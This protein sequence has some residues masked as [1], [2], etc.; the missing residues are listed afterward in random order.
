MNDILSLSATE[1]GRR[2]KAGDISPVDAVDACLARI[3]ATEP[4]LNAYVRVLADEARAA[5]KQAEK[6]IAA[7]QW[8]GPMH[9][10]PVAL[11]DLYDLAHVPTTASS[12]V[13]E[14]W[15]P[16]ADS[17]AA[18]RL[19]AAG[20]IVLGKTHTHEFAYGI[21]T[22]TTR[23]PW[24]TERTPGGSSGGSGA[25]VASS[26]AFMAM[27]S[28]T[29]GSIRIPAGLCGTVGLKP[30]FGRVSRAG[31]TSLSW[32]LDH[33]GPLT[34]TVEDAATCLQV[35][36]GHDPRDPGSGDEPVP[37][38]SA[39]LHDG[40]KG[41]R[42][43]VPTN[44]F[45]DQL[46]PEVEAAVRQAYEQL[47]ALGAELVDV[48]LPMPE[49]I[50]AVEFAILLPEASD[51][52]RQML[53]DSA[54]LYNDDVRVMLEAG[55]FVP[56]TTYIRAQRVR[57][58]L[59]QEFRKLYDKVDVIVAPT[60]AATAVTAGTESITWPDG[61]EE[62]LISA[63]TRFALPGNVTGLPALSVPC[64]FSSEGLPVG[65]QAIGRP[66]DEAT[67]LRLGAAYESATEWHQRRPDI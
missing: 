46:D 26:G 40:I 58:L 57:N 63:Y 31:I 21:V 35:L 49:Q 53:R 12:R 41:L 15:T 43:G 62:P 2:I 11:K 22:P 29:G 39:G 1:L 17:A 16:N 42:V 23:N 30:T 60:I 9:G 27:G 3:E 52:H 33:A 54:H 8:K 13:R 66:F 20:A 64:G 5:A 55:E 61:S 24:D 65:F 28:D 36:A 6:E 19:K 67:I 4:K 56:A 32:G 45:F 10:V 7:G 50:V 38:Y 34:R 48:A 59:Q 25:T 18:E 47:Q 37:D 14:N 44:Y 51:Y